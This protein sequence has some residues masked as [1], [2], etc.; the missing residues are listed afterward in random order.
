MEFLSEDPTYLAGGLG[1]LA[2]SLLIALW[3]TQQGRYLIWALIALGLAAGVLVIEHFWVTDAER[4]ERVVYDLRGAVA[5]ADAD[6]VLTYLTPDVQFAQGGNTSSGEATRAYIRSILT[7]A[8]FDF[9]RIS[10]L[11]AK[12]FSQSRRGSAEFLIIASGSIQGP[13]AQLNFGTTNSAWSLGFDE[14]SPGVWK[15]DRITPTKL[16]GDVPGPSGPSGLG[17]S[18]PRFPIPR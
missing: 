14:I 7:N 1:L 5:D 3:L 12:V 10:Q 13:M 8:K 9:V 6:R 4:I 18:R 15:V 2:L 16:S 17:G 11:R